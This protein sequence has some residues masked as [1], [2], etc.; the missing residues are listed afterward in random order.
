M[1]KAKVKVKIGSW[2]PPTDAMKKINQILEDLK[3]FKVEVEEDSDGKYTLK[4]SNPDNKFITPNLIGPEGKQG[5]SGV[6][7]GS[8]DMPEGYNVQIDP[9]G[10]ADDLSEI[11]SAV[12]TALPKYNGEVTTV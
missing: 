2:A 8:G 12:I 10:E 5:K 3:D 1:I 6:Y 7:V 11:V 4:I 9:D